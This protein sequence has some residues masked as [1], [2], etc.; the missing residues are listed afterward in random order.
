MRFISL[1]LLLIALPPAF[2]AD[3]RVGLRP[4]HGVAID[5]RIESI[6]PPVIERGKTT[7]VSFIGTD[8]GAAL[9]LWHSLP[10]GALKAVPVQ[11]SP[12]RIVMDITASTAAP[13]GV[14]GVRLATKDGLTNACF[15]MVD[16]LPVRSPTLETPLPATVWG[17]FLEGTVD[18]YAIDV[19]AGERI[20]FEVIANRL[21]KNADP[22]LTI[23]DSSGRRVAERDNDPG[24]Y[25]DIRFE[26]CFEVAGRYTVEVRDARFKA[27]EHHHYVLRMGRFPAGRVAVPSAF[28]GGFTGETLLPGTPEHRFSLGMPRTQLGPLFA[29]LKRP[30]DHGSTWVPVAPTLGRGPVTVAEE[31]DAARDSGLSLA[32]SGPATLA[33]M[34]ST[35]VRN[36]FL[37]LD[38]HFMLGRLQ[39][40]RAIVPGTVCGVLR[41]PGEG[42]AFQVHLNKGERI[43]VRGEARALNSPVDL[44][45]ILLDKTGRVQRRAGENPQNPEEASFDFTAPITG[46]YAL[47]VRDAIRDGG[48]SFAYRVTVRDTPFPPQLTAE[49]EGLT[50]PQGNYQPIP[51][52]VVRNG[53]SGPI[54]LHLIGSDGLKLIPDEIGEK[55]TSIVCRLEA[56]GTAALGVHTVQIVAETAGAHGAERTLVLTRPLI[57]MKWQNIDLI[58]IAL[59]EDQ[60]RLPPSLTDRMAVQ[61]TPP[62]PFSFDL[63]EKGVVLPRYRSAAI[64]VATTRVA[65]FD[66]PIAFAARGGQLAEKE[67]GR[68]R[69]Y[70]EFP[71]ATPAQPNISGIVVSK[72]LSN[73][74]RTRIEVT[75]TARRGDRR[76]QLTRA[77]DLNLTTAFQFATD[78]DRVAL[79]PGESTRARIALN[80]LKSYD[81]PV[82]LHL[83]PIAG[84][85]FPETVTLPKGASSAAI[86]I[87]VSLD[88]QPRKQVITVRASGDV[89]GFEEEIRG[90]PI[91]IDVKKPPLPKKK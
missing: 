64:P 50:I 20:S 81:G 12:N 41:T 11:S 55:E 27:S 69:V 34:L 33:F 86:D 83:Q 36:P 52:A 5:N 75:A 77:F 72:I 21:G 13:V 18:R 35:G 79:F 84:I 8:L 70:A 46:E 43:F 76:I 47:V 17:T 30:G 9:D 39:A 66:A 67:E 89:D 42:D 53:Y 38:R 88:F 22:L 44:E 23:R 24:L 16:D 6:A 91:E 74:G 51:I 48:D 10:P 28:E 68:T 4:A 80:R 49:V 29:N 54:K 58:P 31:F 85:N 45:L 62:A 56:S 59:R 82:T 73:V 7:R 65:G 57:D 26:H 1:I 90:A 63:P 87:A 71:S 2:A 60:T 3:P 37:L 25:F 40:T 78:P 19:K 32:T 61:V 15:L 14:C